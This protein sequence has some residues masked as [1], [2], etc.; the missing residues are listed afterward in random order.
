MI[1]DLLFFL[2]LCL[3]FLMLLFN[4]RQMEQRF[5]EHWHYAPKDYNAEL[6]QRKL[7]ENPGYNLTKPKPK[8][9]T[10]SKSYIFWSYPCGSSR[11]DAAC[12]R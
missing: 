10:E 5:A 8:W 7:L 9:Q 12:P 6:T 3:L 4:Q 2:G 1:K 11:Y